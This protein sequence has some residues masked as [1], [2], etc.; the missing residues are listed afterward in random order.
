MATSS[1]SPQQNP[2][3]NPDSDNSKHRIIAITAVIIVALLGVNIFLLVNRAKQSRVNQEL[4]TTL[5]ETEELKADLE[6]Q[7]YEALS[8][9]EEMRGSNEELNALIETQKEKLTES[10]NQIEALL[11][12]KRNLAAARQKINEI[13]AQVEQYVTEINQLRAENEQLASANTELSMAKDSLSTALSTSE[14]TNQELSEARASLV[15]EKEQLLTENT[16][17][18]RRV[19][20]ASVIDVQEIDVTGLR[21][22]NNGKRTSNRKAEKIDEL[23]V[24]FNTTKNEMTEAGVEQFHV[25]IINPRGETMAIDEMGAGILK[26]ADSGE[27]VRYTFTKEVEYNYDTDTYCVVWAPTNYDFQEGVY[28]IEIYNKGHLAGSSNFELR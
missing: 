26:N 19:T 6:K 17:L 11:R 8:E 4:S 24:C 5:T 1:S 10:K 16:D 2:A 21:I 15:S 12:D 14:T 7:Y 25:R 9:L 22:R 20:R 3:P 18:S 27:E 23:E 13:S 28:T